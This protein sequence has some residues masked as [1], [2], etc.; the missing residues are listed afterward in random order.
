MG[1]AAPAPSVRARRVRLDPD[2]AGFAVDVSDWPDMNELMLVA[3]LLVTDFSSAI[4]EFALLDR[5]MA[6]FAPD[7]DAY[8]GERGFYFDFLAGVPGPV[9]EE[10]RDLAAY[11]KADDF[12][13]ARVRAF[14]RTWFDVADG[15]ASERFVDRLVLP[16]LQGRPLQLD[17]GHPRRGRRPLTSSF[18]RGMVPFRAMSAT[19]EIP[20]AFRNAAGSRGPIALVR[21]GIADILSRRRLVRYLVQADVRKRG[22]DTVLGNIWWVL[23]PLLQMLVYVVFITIIVPKTQPDYP[24]FI[25]SAILPWKWFSASIVDATA[26]IVRQ[27]ALIKQIQFPK[28][29]LPVA[30]ATAGI[31]SFAFGTVALG[32]VM[33][34]FSDRITVWLVFIPVIAVVQFV[35]TLACSFLV[36]AG[37][38]FFR[39]LGNVVGHVLRLWWFLSPGLY[40]IESL[41]SIHFF[42]DHPAITTLA[43]A[44]PFAILFEAYR[45]VIYG[46]PTAPPSGPPNMVALA[47]LMAASTAFLALGIVVFKR[48]EP[49]FAKII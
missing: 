5:P 46:T 43:N 33:L 3:D 25:F 1:A 26:S 9:F 37:N 13:L 18:R 34:F 19:S 22:A 6:F 17:P 23:D 2:L 31:V 40:S 42:K 15:H 14:A 29:V 36:A 10:T 30:A 47:V 41:D 44:N 48:L 28:I 7:H 20:A 4:F 8:E 32:L 38:V 35:F 24:L 27:E 39:D 49:N 45:S 12:D 11:V 21:E 16:A